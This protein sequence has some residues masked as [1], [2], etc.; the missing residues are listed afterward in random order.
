MNGGGVSGGH[1][2]LSP[3][4]CEANPS[5]SVAEGIF[6]FCNCA[7]GGGFFEMNNPRS[8]LESH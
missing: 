2:Q 5:G 8:H 6:E 7:G 4:R 3:R 1:D